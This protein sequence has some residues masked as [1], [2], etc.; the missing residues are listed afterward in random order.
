VET[1]FSR[2]V[3][4]HGALLKSIIN[5]K[6]IVKHKNFYLKKVH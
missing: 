2:Y 1:E 5:I 6:G 3:S 4:K